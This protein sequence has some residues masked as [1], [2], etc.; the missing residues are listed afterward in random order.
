MGGSAP[1]LYDN[2]HQNFEFNPRAYSQATFRDSYASSIQTSK[3]KREGPLIDLNRHPDSWV[4][5][6]AGGNDADPLP[7]NFKQKVVITRWVQFALRV[8]TLLGACGLFF[9]AV[10]IKGTIGAEG[11]II[12]VPVG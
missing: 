6:A 7:A 10:C 12:K 8:L 5:V 3:P 2:S 9:C 1:Y 4:I 11:Y